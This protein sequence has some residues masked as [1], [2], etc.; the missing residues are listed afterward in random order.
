MNLHLKW[1]FF[2]AMFLTQTKRAE[3]LSLKLL[4]EFFRDE[5]LKESQYQIKILHF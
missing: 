5:Y 1:Q 3:I 4:L 2:S